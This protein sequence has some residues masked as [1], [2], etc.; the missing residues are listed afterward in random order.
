MAKRDEVDRQLAQKY[1]W[2]L[3]VPT[4]PIQIEEPRGRARPEEPSDAAD[5]TD[6]APDGESDLASWRETSITACEALAAAVDRVWAMAEAR[7]PRESQRAGD[8]ADPRAQE[9]AALPLLEHASTL[10]FS[11]TALVRHP[12]QGVR[13]VRLLHRYRESLPEESRDALAAATLWLRFEH[14]E[15]AELLIEVAAA[16]DSWL[17]GRL[18]LPLSSL[19]REHGA[20]PFA[21]HPDFVHRLVEILSTGPSWDSREIALGWL[22]L[23]CSAAAIPALRRALRLPHIGIRGRALDLLL[24]KFQP[25]AVEAED[26]GFLLADLF[27]HPPPQTRALFEPLQLYA[28]ALL[29]AVAALRP[30]GSDEVLLRMVR[31]EG[32]PRL[33]ATGDFDRHWALRALAAAYPERALPHVD[34]FLGAEAWGRYA[35]VRAAEKLP[36]ELARPRLLRGAGD[37]APFVAE[38]ARDLWLERFGSP[39]PV[40]P[41]AG[42]ETALLTGPPSER[43]ASRLLVLRGRSVAARQAMLEVLFDEAPD[44][45]ALALI[46]FALADDTLLYERHR[47]RLPRD[48]DQLASRLYRRFGSEA[49]RGLCLVAGRYPGVCAITWLRR[50]HGLASAKKL[51]KRDYPLLREL[52]AGQID[53]AVAYGRLAA[54]S[55][56]SAIGAPVRLRP[57]LLEIVISGADGWAWATDI[58]A[59]WPADAELDA[60]LGGEASEA[61]R[62]GNVARAARLCHAGFKRGIPALRK[63]AGDALDTWISVESDGRWVD[64]GEHDTR[65]TATLFAL[66]C[67]EYLL[68]TGSLSKEWIT[69]ALR[70]PRS[71]AFVLAA[72]HLRKEHVADALPALIGALDSTAR[73]YESAA[74][75]ATT[76]VRHDA[77]PVDDPRLVPLLG[78]APRE[79]RLFLLFLLVY[80]KAPLAPLRPLI[81]ELFMSTSAHEV[82]D[83][84]R[85]IPTLSEALDPTAAAALLPQIRE[86]ELREQ[87]ALH[88]HRKDPPPAY[89]QDT[90]DPT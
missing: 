54:L 35:A 58:L 2:T 11:L 50:L 61:W 46:A 28:Q 84:V 14:P 23:S 9:Q 80:L 86:T 30:P 29:R 51:R 89:W 44:A 39:C 82:K 24:D 49:L 22:E 15:T 65:Q 4:G 1:A 16:G 3:A 90:A 60:A 17:A 75:A 32:V 68:H 59:K 73:G 88:L 69:E 63:L 38:T 12:R 81:A 25:P 64:A 34:H 62:A 85:Y 83:L 56:M 48:L 57:R 8:P 20:R 66:S 76:L 71:P 47:R 10:G 77:L 52:A 40:E 67:L 37:G 13:L 33:L 79:Q 70:D 6:V 5:E 36:D 87:I 74:E 18:A 41:L 42:V 53:S 26:V 21:D 55:M 7:D 78:R 45:E 19:R 43:M 31:G 72:R 27:E